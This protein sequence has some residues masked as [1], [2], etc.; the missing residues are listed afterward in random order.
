MPLSCSFSHEHVVHFPLLLKKFR[1]TPHK[2]TTLSEQFPNPI[3]KSLTEA[4]IYT[5]PLK[6]IHDHSFSYLGTGI[7]INSAGAKLILLAQMLL[8]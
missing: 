6:H 2:I 1:K 8:F 4:K 3:E 7:S 5:I